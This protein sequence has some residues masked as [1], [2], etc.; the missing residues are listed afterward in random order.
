MDYLFDTP[1][2]L[3][4]LLADLLTLAITVLVMLFV[5]KKSR[6]PAMVLLEALA[7]V[8]FYASLYENFAVVQ[9]WYLYGHSLLTVGD[10]PLSVPLLEVDVLITVL[11]LLEK[12]EIPTWC[13]PFVAGLFGLLQDF[14]LDPYSIRQVYT[15]GERMTGRWSWILPEGAVNIYGVPVYNFPG[16]TLIMLYATVFILLGREWFKRSGYRPVVGYTYPFLMIFLALLAM[17]SPLSQF[18]LWLGPLFSRGSNA[19]WVMLAFHLLFPTILLLVFWRGRMKTPL[20]LG[21][22]LPVF[23]VIGLFHLADILFTVAGGYY[24]IL[25]LVV[26]TSMVH[27]AWLGWIYAAGRKAPPHKAGFVLGP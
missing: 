10:V 5:I 18:L 6:H 8:L 25:W 22:D 4:W 23:A 16:W 1:I 26:M 14:S 9:G 20:T 19:E 27:W 15:V 11:W 3:P 17:V 13:K 12:M 21:Q 2:P 7:F 24:E